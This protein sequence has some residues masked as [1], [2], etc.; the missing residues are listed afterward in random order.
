MEDRAIQTEDKGARTKDRGIQTEDRRDQV[1]PLHK[2]NKGVSWGNHKERGVTYT[3]H[4]ST[5]PWINALAKVIETG[6]FSRIGGK[7]FCNVSPKPRDDFG[8]FDRRFPREFWM[9]LATT[10]NES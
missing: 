3:P 10:K 1:H 8:M 4:R 7:R 5:W 2:K 6:I 9:A